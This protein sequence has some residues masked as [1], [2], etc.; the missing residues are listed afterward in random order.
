MHRHL[1]LQHEIKRLLSRK[2]KSRLLFGFTLLAAFAFA[3]LALRQLRQFNFVCQTPFSFHDER[4]SDFAIELN[5]CIQQG[6]SRLSEKQ[7]YTDSVQ[8]AHGL[9][10]HQLLRVY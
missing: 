3:H 4:R 5:Y 9:C 6:M 2:I 7:I 1:L 8:Y 10:E